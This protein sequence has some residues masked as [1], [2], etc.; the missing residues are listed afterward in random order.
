MLT[1]DPFVGSAPA[2]VRRCGRHE[3]VRQ[4]KS[5]CQPAHLPP[6]QEV[7]QEMSLVTLHVMFLSVTAEQSECSSYT[8]ICCCII[9]ILPRMTCIS[10][11]MN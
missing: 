2:A 5:Q 1:S 8:P 11:N 6:E 3:D 7:L 9:L 10:S 4:S